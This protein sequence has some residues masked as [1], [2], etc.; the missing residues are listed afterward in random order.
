MWTQ[1]EHQPAY[2]ADSESFADDGYFFLNGSYKME[3]S[4]PDPDL[5]RPVMPR[6]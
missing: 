1:S 2:D 3:H 6:T 5:S 4:A